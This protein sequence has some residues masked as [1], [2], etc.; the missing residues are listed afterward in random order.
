MKIPLMIDS[1][2]YSAYTNK[3][4][5]DIDKYINFCHEEL[6]KYPNITYVVLDIMGEGEPTYRNWKIMKKAGLNPLPIYHVSTDVKWLKKYLRQTDYIG[7]GAIANLS[8]QKRMISLDRI[9]ETYLID[10]NSM[11]KYKIHGMGITSF[12]L[13]RRYPW[14]SIDSTSWLQIGIYGKILL[15]KY[16]KG[17][18]IYDGDPFTIG[19]STKSPTKKEKGKHIDNVSLLEKDLLMRYLKNVGFKLGKSK[20]IEKEKKGKKIMK[21]E[22]IEEGISNNF[23]QR[24]FLNAL[25]YSKYSQTLPYPR[26]MKTKRIKGLIWNTN[27]EQ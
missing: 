12:S 21:E 17:C 27:Q 8:S 2:A 9:W 6:I 15:P 5:I 26:P 22:I 14:Y 7:I 10:E 19:F 3:S 25:Y 20:F 4:E 23:E 16:R 13:M 24:C 18:W 1:G 11:P